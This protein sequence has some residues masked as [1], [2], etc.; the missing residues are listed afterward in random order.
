MWFAIGI[1][2]IVTWIPIAFRPAF[3]ARGKGQLRALPLALLY[4]PPALLTACVARDRAIVV[5]V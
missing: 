1:V 3:V 5:A 4:F 2:G